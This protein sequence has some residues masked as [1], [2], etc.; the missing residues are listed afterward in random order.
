[1]LQEERNKFKPEV[2]LAANK[3]WLDW[4]DQVIPQED[5]HRSFFWAVAGHAYKC[6]CC[7]DADPVDVMDS[8]IAHCTWN[9]VLCTVLGIKGTELHC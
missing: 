5:R 1:M 3:Y 2:N 6:P 7:E 9:K 8:F 4:K